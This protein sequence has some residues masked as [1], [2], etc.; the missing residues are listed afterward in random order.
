[1]RRRACVH[2]CCCF[3]LSLCGMMCCHHRIN[4]LM[5]AKF[6]LC[7]HAET[8]KPRALSDPANEEKYLEKARA[9]QSFGSLI[10]E[11]A[12]LAEGHRKD[13]TPC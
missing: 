13:P 8:S 3:S 1:M 12:K 10:I 4:L 9:S 2:Y 5:F 11:A 7:Q 6:S